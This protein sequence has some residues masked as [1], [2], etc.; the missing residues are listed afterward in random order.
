[1]KDVRINSD[2]PQLLLVT[3][4]CNRMVTKFEGFDLLEVSLIRNH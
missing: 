4:D 1:M 3:S 2:A